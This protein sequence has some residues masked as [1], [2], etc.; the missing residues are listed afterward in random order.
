M[1]LYEYRC[2]CGWGDEFVRKY[3]VSR[4]PVECED[5]GDLATLVL[6]KPAK[7]VRRWGDSHFNPYYDHGLGLQ[8]RSPQHRAQVMK[9]RGLRQLEP[10]EVEAEQRI[11]SREHAAPQENMAPYNRVLGDTGSVLKA[12]EQTFP[13]VEV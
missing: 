3:E 11:S 4:R 8:V 12:A 5:C 1:P 13:D 9:E 6:P 2:S 10:G 7:P